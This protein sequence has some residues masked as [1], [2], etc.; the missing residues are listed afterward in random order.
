M[1]LN[2]ARQ[3]QQQQQ[4][5]TNPMKMS[6]RSLLLLKEFGTTGE[7][8]QLPDSCKV[9]FPDAP[10]TQTSVTTAG[11][12][13]R[14]IVHYAPTEGLYAGGTFRIEFDVNKVPNYPMQPP[15]ARMLTKVWHPN[16]DIN[17][18]ICHNYLKTEEAFHGGWTPAL[19]M[20]AL[21]HAILTMFDTKSDS[22]NPEDPLNMEATAQL[23][24]NR[25]AF[26]RQARE[27]VKQYAK[28]VQIAPHCLAY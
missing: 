9:E 12:Y 18:A 26:E 27:W 16:I 14:F 6:M 22:F 10:A 7:R 25:D 20:Q 19:K 1:L 15:K 21:V 23:V 3:Q 13:K 24:S 2:R 8:M 28:P 5:G 17:G 4:Q 11:K